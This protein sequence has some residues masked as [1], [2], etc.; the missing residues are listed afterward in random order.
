MRYIFIL[1]AGQNKYNID[2]KKFFYR[3]EKGDG[4]ISV[5]NKFNLPVFTLIKLN[6]LTGEIQAGD[7]LY[8]ETCEQK[9]YTVQPFETAHDLSVRFNKDEKNIL[10]QNGVEYIYYGMKIYL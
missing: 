1:F 8:I 10:C 5:A 2:M 7:L 9:L 6:N 4:V 3:V